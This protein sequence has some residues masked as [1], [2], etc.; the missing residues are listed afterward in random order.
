MNLFLCLN[1]SHFKRPILE[2][3]SY[4][5]SISFNNVAQ[6]AAWRF[7]SLRLDALQRPGV[8]A[9]ARVAT[10]PNKRYDRIREVGQGFKKNS[11]SSRKVNKHFS[12][13]HPSVFLLRP[14][15]NLPLALMFCSIECSTSSCQNIKPAR[16]GGVRSTGEMKMHNDPFSTDSIHANIFWKTNLGKTKMEPDTVLLKRNI[17]YKPSIFGVPS[18]KLT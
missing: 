4:Q 15:N 9:L 8:S 5:V 3:C 2:R 16:F 6:V 11:Q 14:L 13:L 10:H 7:G 17:I 18:G 12:R 1:G